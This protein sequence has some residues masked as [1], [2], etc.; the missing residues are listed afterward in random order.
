[1][2]GIFPVKLKKVIEGNQVSK[3]INPRTVHWMGPHWIMKDFLDLRI[4]LLLNI[5]C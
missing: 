1:M 4:H 2:W 5:V 3:K